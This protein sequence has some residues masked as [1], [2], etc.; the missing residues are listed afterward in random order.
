MRVLSIVIRL[1]V[2]AFAL[3]ALLYAIRVFFEYLPTGVVE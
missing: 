3:S 2:Y 1:A